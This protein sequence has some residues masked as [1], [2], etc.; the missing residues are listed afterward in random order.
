MS[1]V[2][3]KYTLR[4]VVEPTMGVIESRYNEGSTENYSCIPGDETD[5]NDCHYPSR[6]VES[7][8]SL[9]WGRGAS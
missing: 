5:L 3:S 2:T 1:H 8:L 9:P 4:W 6:T 7:H